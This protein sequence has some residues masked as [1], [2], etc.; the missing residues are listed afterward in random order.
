MVVPIVFAAVLSLLTA[1]AEKPLCCYATERGWIV[2]TL[3]SPDLHILR[4]HVHEGFTERIVL[5]SSK[6]TPSNLKSHRLSAL[7]VNNR[8]I[9]EYDYY[10][11][12]GWLPGDGAIDKRCRG[13]CSLKDLFDGKVVDQIGKTTSLYFKVVHSATTGDVI[14][15]TANEILGVHCYENDDKTRKIGWFRGGG[16]SKTVPSKEKYSV[17]CPFK[18]HFKCINLKDRYYFVTDS[19]TLY[20]SSCGQDGKP[21]EILPVFLGFREP[22]IAVVPVIRLK[23]TYIFTQNR[24]FELSHNVPS[25]KMLREIKNTSFSK[26]DKMVD[27][28]S[29]RSSY[30][31]YQ[32]CL[33]K[34]IEHI[35]IDLK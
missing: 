2:Y 34:V 7:V 33:D 20:T 29:T 10:F 22:I 26:V 23:K 16:L 9:L 21:Q 24:Y 8:L 28:L 14:E 1:P 18:G 15:T 11:S 19:G 13:E 35:K 17:P 5:L 32:M 30:I 3:G 6:L 31:Y 12:G 25:P 4:P 27:D